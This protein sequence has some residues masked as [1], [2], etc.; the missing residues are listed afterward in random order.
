MKNHSIFGSFK[1]AFNGVKSAFKEEPNLRIH[2]VFAAFSLILAFFLH[3]SG[4]EWTILFTTI[5]LV[6]VTE[7]LNTVLENIVDLVSPQIQEKAR[8]AKDVSA[9]SV[10]VVSVLAVVVGIVLFLPKILTLL[11]L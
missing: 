11:G 10:L 2:F 4:V 7:F 8:I 5:T 6:V 3:L 9:A 1:F